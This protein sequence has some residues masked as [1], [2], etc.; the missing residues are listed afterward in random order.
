MPVAAA[1]PAVAS[2]VGGKMQGDA[3]AQA[4]AAQTQAGR[5]A[6]NA[7][8]AIYNQSRADTLPQQVTGTGA[9]NLLAQLYGLPT[10]QGGLNTGGITVTGGE[11]TAKKKKRSFFDKVTD[12]ANL[13]KQFG[14]TSYDPLGFFSGG[15][16]GEVSPMQFNVGGAGGGSVVPGAGLMGGSGAGDFSQFY[17]TP[18]YLVAMGEG[19]RGLDRSLASRGALGSGGADADRLQFASNLGTQAFGNFT[20]NLFRLAGFGSQ[21]NQQLNSLGQNFGSAAAQQ[22][23][24]IG[25]ARAS[26]YANQSNAWGNALGGAANAFGQFAGSRQAPAQYYSPPPSQGFASGFGNNTGWLSG[27][28]YS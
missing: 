11:P 18:D 3:A 20:N 16:G 13:A 23:G 26:S 12:P 6:I 17:Q 21:G 10:Y 28:G 5:D 24:N 2:L 1:I 27:G 19:L 25:D 15:G 9:L 4:G 14:G 22:F 7:Q 8:L